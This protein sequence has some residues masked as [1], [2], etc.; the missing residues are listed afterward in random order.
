MNS[1]PCE[2]SHLA[3]FH[4]IWMK[5]HIYDDGRVRPESECACSI[6]GEKECIWYIPADNL[7]FLE[8]QYE[9]SKAI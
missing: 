2:C 7:K 3:K 6:C 1:W 4:T 9:Q 8:Q 5:A